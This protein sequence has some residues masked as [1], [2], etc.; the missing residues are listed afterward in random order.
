MNNQNI[1][2]SSGQ[3]YSAP[4]VNHQKAKKNKGISAVLIIFSIIFFIA[5]GILLAMSFIDLKLPLK[6][7]NMTTDEIIATDESLLCEKIDDSLLS[8]L[9]QQIDVKSFDSLSKLTCVFNSSDL[10]TLVDRYSDH[11]NSYTDI[12]LRHYYDMDDFDSDGEYEAVITIGFD[13]TDFVEKVDSYE[14]SEEFVDV[15]YYIGDYVVFLL[16][17][18][19][20]ENVISFRPYMHFGEFNDNSEYRVENNVLY[21]LNG[22]G[23]TGYYCLPDSSTIYDDYSYQEDA[24]RK[25]CDAY[26]NYLIRCGNYDVKYVCADVA[27]A[28]GEEILFISKDNSGYY[29]VEI[30]TFI[31]GRA[32]HLYSNP[33][34]ECATYLIEIDSETYILEYSQNLGDRYNNYN[35][36]Y[37][38][39]IFRLDSSY[40]AVESERASTEVIYGSSSAESE[41]FFEKLN[42]YLESVIV[43]ADP[44]ELTGY[45]EPAYSTGMSTHSNNN[46]DIYEDNNDSHYIYITNCPT[47]KMGV[48]NV[49]EYSYLNFREGPSTDYDRILIDSSDEKS[50]VRQLRGSSVTVIDTEN[51]FDEDNPVWL[52]IQIKYNGLTLI[53]YSSQAYIDLPGIKRIQTG[54]SFTITADSDDNDIVWSVNDSAIAEIDPDTGKLTGLNPGVVIVSAT[55]SSGESDSCLV[56]IY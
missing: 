41:R 50:F 28:P 7:N 23:D 1:Q 51:T 4:A 38:Y 48:V 32:H 6:N 20:Y 52:K 13:V 44:Y 15:E 18:D 12:G 21:V 56:E 31:G 36:H 40:N 24:F 49:P 29:Y 42:S 16:Y 9:Y 46:A 5:S 37:S 25:M 34:E 17:A 27:D 45:S 33:Y 35:A 2:N 8:F 26:T 30:V 14:A 19:V 11:L 39:K 55:S 3:H 53:G 54:E 22:K 43:V 10:Q 47:S